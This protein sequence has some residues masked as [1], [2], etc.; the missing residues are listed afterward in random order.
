MTLEFQATPEEVMRAVDALNAFGQARQLPEQT[1]FGLTL[2][3]EE[4]ASN[5][6]NHAL[7]QDA[8]QTFR[9]A[10]ELTDGTLTVELRDTGPE[11][12]PT[13]EP[14]TELTADAED[15]ESREPGGWGLQLVRRYTDAVRHTRE[16]GTNVL[17]LTRKLPP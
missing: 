5:I 9:V 12:D 11:F 14:A 2:A 7:Q 10:F 4:C 8:Q 16:Q 13:L 3:L 15:D 6:V 17:R 1:L